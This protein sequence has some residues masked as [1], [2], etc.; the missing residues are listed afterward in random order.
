MGN[1]NRIEL[2]G[3]GSI[4]QTILHFTLFAAL[5]HSSIDQYGSPARV[6]DVRRPRDLSA[7]CS[8]DFDPHVP[9]LPTDA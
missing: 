1:Q 8:N 5:K 7:S 6:D 9:P 2:I 3:P 4:G